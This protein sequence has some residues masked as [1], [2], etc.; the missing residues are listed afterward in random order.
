L[1]FSLSDGNQSVSLAI[2][3]K[4]LSPAVQGLS[5]VICEDCRFM[6]GADGM[7]IGGLTALFYSI[8]IDYKNAR[9][10]FKPKPASA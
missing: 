9:I 10:G 1:A 3:T 2:T 4:A 8:L 5:L 7:N 6:S